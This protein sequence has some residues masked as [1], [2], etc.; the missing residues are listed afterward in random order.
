M[1]PTGGTPSDL[2]RRRTLHANPQPP[3]VQPHHSA[4]HHD[5]HRRVKINPVSTSG[6]QCY[7]R[8]ACMLNGSLL[9]QAHNFIETASALTVLRLNIYVRLMQNNAD[10]CT[11]E[12]RKMTLGKCIVNL[13]KI[14]TRDA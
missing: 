13:D 4:R 1:P 10:R 3:T 9:M 11:N 8:L 12:I 14:L 6:A 7:P 2:T 5:P